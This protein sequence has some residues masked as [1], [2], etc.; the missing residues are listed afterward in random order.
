MLGFWAIAPG[1]QVDYWMDVK[2]DVW[3]NYRKLLLGCVSERC[4]LHVLLR[5]AEFGWP[6]THNPPAS[7]P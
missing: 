5:Q 3:A 1:H 6:G 7:V 2:L 4:L